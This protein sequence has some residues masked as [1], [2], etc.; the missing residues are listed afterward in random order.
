M[1]MIVEGRRKNQQIVKKEGEDVCLW[2]E[3]INGKERK[4]AIIIRF[5]H[6]I[7]CMMSCVFFCS[8][9]ICLIL[10]RMKFVKWFVNISL[11]L[12]LK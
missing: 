11:F 1:K 8:F 7:L 4:Q 10:Q 5:L 3:E 12:L 6:F 2:R 9:K